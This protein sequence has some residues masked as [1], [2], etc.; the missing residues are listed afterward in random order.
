MNFYNFDLLVVPVGIF[1][2]RAPLVLIAG[3]FWAPFFH[4]R[5][6][7]TAKPKRIIREIPEFSVVFFGGFSQ[8]LNEHFH[9]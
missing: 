8:K 7:R 1:D 5:S 2:L 4:G 9:A 3:V 6:P